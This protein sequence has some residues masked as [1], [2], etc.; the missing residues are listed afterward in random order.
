MSERLH[1]N[2]SFFHVY[3]HPKK[4][5]SL[6]DTFITNWQDA[7]NFIPKNYLKSF[8][9]ILFYNLI[10]R[11]CFKSSIKNTSNIDQSEVDLYRNCVSKHNYSIGVFSNI[12]QSSRNWKGFLSYIDVREYSRHPEEMGTTI[13]TNP[14]IRKHVLDMQKI[15]E[16]KE[17]GNAL[18]NL[19]KGSSDP[20][21]LNFVY[22]YKNQKTESVTQEE[23]E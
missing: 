9:S 8:D 3:E 5:D 10:H 11:E 16:N 19:L 20:K 13:P 12:L 23:S 1:L 15:K 7:Q 21:P 18:E 2:D 14:I 6:K 4:Y 22:E 17:R